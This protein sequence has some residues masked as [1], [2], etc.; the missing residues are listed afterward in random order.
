[1]ITN[2]RHDDTIYQIRIEYYSS[3]EQ[4]I[5]ELTCYS[6]NGDMDEIFAWVRNFIPFVR[7]HIDEDTK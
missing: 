7:L 3:F 2:F 4:K 1:M 6:D 5:K